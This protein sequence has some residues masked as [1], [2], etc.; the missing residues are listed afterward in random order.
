[1]L[2][3]LDAT[4][5]IAGPKGVR[6]LPLEQYFVLPT[7]GHAR[8]DRDGNPSA[9]DGGEVDVSEIQGTLEPGFRDGIGR[10][11]GGFQR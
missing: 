6:D 1:M 7:P 11:G 4:V 10:G 2:I 3:A 9:G 8:K 5:T